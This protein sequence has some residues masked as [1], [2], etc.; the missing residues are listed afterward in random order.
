MQNIDTNSILININKTLR[1]IHKELVINNAP[2]HLRNV[3]RKYYT[4]NHLHRYYN[5]IAL[6]VQRDMTEISR[7]LTCAEAAKIP[8]YVEM[9]KLWERCIEK[10]AQYSEELDELIAEGA[11]CED[12]IFFD[13]ER[14]SNYGPFII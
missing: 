12:D 13:I 2:S 1:L 10:T 9:E 5:S 3:Q 4:A 8:E 11:I 7:G 6:N 14:E